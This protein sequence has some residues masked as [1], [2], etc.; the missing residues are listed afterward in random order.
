MPRESVTVTMPC[1]ATPMRRNFWQHAEHCAT[2]E[3]HARTMTI[4]WT[5]AMRAFLILDVPMSRK[6]WPKEEDPPHAPTP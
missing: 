2:C 6:P 3:R 5:R 1:G 4:A